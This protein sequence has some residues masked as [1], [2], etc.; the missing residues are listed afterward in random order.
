MPEG[1]ISLVQLMT[2]DSVGVLTGLPTQHHSHN[3][4]TFGPHGRLTL[5]ALLISGFAVLA[6]F[7]KSKFA[8]ILLHLVLS[9]FAGK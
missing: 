5:L 2:P 6:L 7:V 1:N 3:I 9:V 8:P 4:I